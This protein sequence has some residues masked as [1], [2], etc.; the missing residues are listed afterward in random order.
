VHDAE[1][2]NIWRAEQPCRGNIGQPWRIVEGSRGR[3]QGNVRHSNYY[4]AAG[5]SKT[6]RGLG[7]VVRS[8]WFSGRARAFSAAGSSWAGSCKSLRNGRRDKEQRH[9]GTVGLSLCFSSSLPFRYRHNIHHEYSCVPAH[10]V[11]RL[12][13][14][15]QPHTQCQAPIDIESGLPRARHVCF[16]TR[17]NSLALS[18]PPDSRRKVS[19]LDAPSQQR[20]F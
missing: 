10:P 16:V 1:S 7:L 14:Q 13:Q 3:N 18:N 5:I 12:A 20:H 8:E 19:V 9:A 11:S 15:L 2:N 6:S 17:C 4:S